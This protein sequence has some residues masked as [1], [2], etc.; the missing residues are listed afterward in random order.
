MPP[1]LAERTRQAP[2]NPPPR[3]E[4]IANTYHH[5]IPSARARRTCQQPHHFIDCTC[6]H[7]APP[8]LDER[9]RPSP[10]HFAVPT[11]PSQP[12]RAMTPSSPPPS[13]ARLIPP[14]THGALT[15][16]RPHFA[17]TCRQTPSRSRALEGG[18]TT[19]RLDTS[20][21]SFWTNFIVFFHFIYIF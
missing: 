19:K 11:P 7:L 12:S 21:E 17:L 1:T 20:L 4:T 10:P 9:L 16:P 14:S 2:L 3:F 6:H 13:M 18:W 5:L 15:G 8:I